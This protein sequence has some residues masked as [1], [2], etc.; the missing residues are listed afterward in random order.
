MV[1]GHQESDKWDCERRLGR[2]KKKSRN[3]F[4]ECS[5][6]KRISKKNGEKGPVVQ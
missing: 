6:V 4:G 3:V 5:D 1:G 2:R